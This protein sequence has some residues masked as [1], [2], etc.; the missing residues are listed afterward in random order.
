MK[1]DNILSLIYMQNDLKA[2]HLPPG[3]RRSLYRGFALASVSLC[4]ERHIMDQYLLKV[5]EPLHKR[6]SNFLAHGKAGIHNE[7][8]QNELIDICEC[9][10]GISMGSSL[11]SAHRIFEHMH[12]MIGS[13]VELFKNYYNYQLIVQSILE[14]LSHS[15]RY[16]VSYLKHDQA[17][18]MYDYCIDVVTSYAKCHAN[19]LTSDTLAEE[20]TS[21]DLLYMVDILTHLLSKDYL[22]FCPSDSPEYTVKASTHVMRG[23]CA[24]MPFMKPDLL[25]FPNLC[26]QYYRLLSHVNEVCQKDMCTL[27]NGVLVHI[28]QYI[29][30]G[31]SQ[32]G[33][34]ITPICLDFISRVCCHMFNLKLAESPMYEMLKPCMKVILELTL[35][36]HFENDLICVVADC[37]Y[38]LICCYP[39]EFDVCMKI[40]IANQQDPMVADRLSASFDRMLAGVEFDNDRHS[41]TKFKVNFEKFVSNV[42]GFLLVK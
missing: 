25:K 18:K 11:R 16:L 32:F 7:Y 42:K 19:R 3:V 40:L 21:Q 31:L 27:D 22:D 37:V 6:Y 4:Q 20:T 38:F 26:L 2:G 35:S 14:L 28:L 30:L 17:Q 5:F 1:P 10:I 39:T 15:A 23:F 8:I 13:I 12:Q 41:K 36:N 24:I 33:P 34:E 29:E 9:L